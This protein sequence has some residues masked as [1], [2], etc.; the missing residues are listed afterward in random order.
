MEQ[1][2]PTT[3][4]DPDVDLIPNARTRTPLLHAC[5]SCDVAT[6]KDLLKRGANP[7]ATDNYHGHTALHLL[8]GWGSK[9]CPPAELEELIRLFI[10]RGVPI[11]EKDRD[12]MTAMHSAAYSDNAVAARVLLDAGIDFLLSDSEYQSPL[13]RAT[14]L[15]TAPTVAAMLTEAEAKRRQVWAQERQQKE[16]AQAAAK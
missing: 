8:C 5:D 9:H 4:A 11:D 13:E 7:L 6:I 10:A 3:P 14:Y 12:G 16:Q 15:N 1:K 2:A